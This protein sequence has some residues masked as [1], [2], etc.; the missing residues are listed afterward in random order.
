MYCLGEWPLRYQ[1]SIN[2]KWPQPKPRE[3]GYCFSDLLSI[4]QLWHN[5]E[6]MGHQEDWTHYYVNDI[7][8]QACQPLHQVKVPFLS[9]IW[10][11]CR[12]G[13][14][15]CVARLSEV[16]LLESISLHLKYI[17]D[18]R[19]I[20]GLPLSRTRVCWFHQNAFRPGCWLKS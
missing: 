11:E 16:D 10:I 20:K 9:N 19:E 4:A 14:H 18:I 15:L 12:R 1:L 5:L 13:V 6:S 2:L 17:A 8:N 7:A 3:C